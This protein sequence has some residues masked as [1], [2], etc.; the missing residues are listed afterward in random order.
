MFNR[1]EEKM[2][3]DYESEDSLVLKWMKEDFANK[4]EKY[5]GNKVFVTKQSRMDKVHL[6]Q[7]LKFDN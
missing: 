2:G 6:K 3:Y 7:K 5:L 1:F 4:M